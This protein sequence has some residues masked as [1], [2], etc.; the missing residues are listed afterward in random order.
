MP[1][2]LEQPGSSFHVWAEGYEGLLYD[3]HDARFRS[4]IYGWDTGDRSA[5]IRAVIPAQ[6]AAWG[7]LAQG[8]ATIASAGARPRAIHEVE[9]FV[10]ANGAELILPPG[11]RLF[12]VQQ[13]G[14]LAIPL[15]GGPI[16]P[17]G[18]LRY[19]DGCS[20]SLLV[21]PPVAGEP[22]LNHLHFPPNIVQTRHTHPSIRAGIIARGTG[23]CTTGSG[24]ALLRSGLIF[25]IPTSCI[26]GFQTSSERMDV[27]AYHP[28][29]NHGPRHE[30][31]PMINR[32]LVEGRKIDNSLGPHLN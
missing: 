28:D 27:I 21:P 3:D 9:F 29:S 2:E 16:E 7:F 30:D 14:F 22:C 19:F 25:V 18:R 6:G 11:A 1:T 13:I 4:L 8:T 12:A 20:D 31:H 32:T 17:R 10:T 26:H 23:S 5:Q 15:I 24:V